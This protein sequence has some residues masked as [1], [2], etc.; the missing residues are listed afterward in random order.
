MRNEYSRIHPEKRVYTLEGPMHKR[1]LS[2][3]EEIKGEIIE[4]DI[5][6][7]F[8]RNLSFGNSGDKNRTRNRIAIIK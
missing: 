2:L 7:S 3:E 8:N 4:P 1:D 6:A 5:R